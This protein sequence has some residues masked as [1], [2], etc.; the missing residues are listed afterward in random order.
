MNYHLKETSLR[1]QSLSH[2]KTHLNRRIL[3]A[4]P[5]RSPDK[6][7]LYPTLLHDQTHKETETR[8]RYNTTFPLFL[9][10]FRVRP[11]KGKLACSSRKKKKKKKAVACL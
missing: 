1:G 9:E 11:D 4:D 7:L 3:K 5:S 6:Q 8:Q 10:E 2:F